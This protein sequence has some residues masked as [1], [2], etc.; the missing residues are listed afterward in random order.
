MQ[1]VKEESGSIG[2]KEVVFMVIQANMTSKAITEVWE[3]TI[4]VFLKYNIPITEKALQQLVDDNILQVLL[5]DL[6]HVVGSSN[7][8]CI[9]GG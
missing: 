7:A 3:D 2:N 8:T 5:T 4:K 6:N 9:V 1:V